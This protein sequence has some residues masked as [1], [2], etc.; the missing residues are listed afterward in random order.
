MDIGKSWSGFAPGWL[1]WVPGWVV[2]GGIYYVLHFRWK[3]F[4]AIDPG[5]IIYLLWAII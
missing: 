4:C 2:N 5:K 3:F 1:R